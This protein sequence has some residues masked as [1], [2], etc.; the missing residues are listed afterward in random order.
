M[1]GASELLREG[2]RLRFWLSGRAGRTLVVF[3]HGA[4]LD[5]REWADTLPV[6]EAAHHVLCWDVRGPAQSRPTGAPWT[7]A[8]AASDLLAV[9]DA[10]GPGPVILV[11]HSM[12][13][14]IA[15]EVIFRAPARVKAAVL[16]GCTS[17]TQRLSPLMRA[18]ASLSAPL[19]NV[20][21]YAWLRRTSAE[22][23]SDRPAV[24]AY[25]YDA[26]GR[27]D[28]SDFKRIVPQLFNDLHAEPGYT[29]PVPF[30][31][32]HGENDRAGNI[33]A[34]AP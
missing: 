25:L 9:L 24:R 28:A 29:I 1:Q 2:C 10:V 34:I 32:L 16:L 5:H 3:T 12:G 7:L 8:R 31:L 20:A 21:P 22:L 14:N 15:Q 18:I 11:G 19:I 6:V 27:M 23:Y 4:G 13:G 17:N 26:F 33:R 30:L